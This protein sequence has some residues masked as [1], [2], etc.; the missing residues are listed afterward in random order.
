[1]LTIVK[2]ARRAHQ[3]AVGRPSQCRAL[4]KRKSSEQFDPPVEWC[5]SHSETSFFGGISAV[6]AVWA[7][8]YVYTRSII[9]PACAAHIGWCCGNPT[10]TLRITRSLFDCSALW[11]MLAWHHTPW[12]HGFVSF[13]SGRSGQAGRQARLKA[14]PVSRT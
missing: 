1:M 10:S 9:F 6:H 3:P 5:D 2:E 14:S 7:S 11:M 13:R 4:K 12:I 8:I